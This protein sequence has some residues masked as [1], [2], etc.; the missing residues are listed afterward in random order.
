[1][2]AT[3][4]PE[5]AC[6]PEQALVAK[7]GRGAARMQEDDGLVRGDGALADAGDQTGERLP[8][9]HRIEQ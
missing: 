4:S 1:M 7:E 3:V 2:R 5:T 9:I 8:G 6:S